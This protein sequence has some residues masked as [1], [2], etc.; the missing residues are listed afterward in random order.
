MVAASPGADGSWLTAARNFTKTKSESLAAR[1]EIYHYWG[2]AWATLGLL[3]TIGIVPDQ[4]PVGAGLTHADYQEV[5]R[6]YAISHR[7]DGKPYLAEALHPDTGSFEGHDGYNHSEHYFHSG[8]CDLIITGLVGVVPSVD[9]EL[10]I[11]PLAPADWDYFALDQLQYQGHTLTVFW[12]RTGQR[13]GHGAGLQVW[14]NGK[15]VARSQKLEALEV[16]LPDPPETAEPSSTVRTNFAVNNDGWYFPRFTSSFANPQTP[17]NKLHDG[18]S[19]YH[20][21]PPN[22]W[23]CQGSPNPVDWVVVDFGTARTFDEIQLY[24]LD[25]DG[26]TPI[27][28]PRSATLESWQEGNWQPIAA[29]PAL[30]APTGHRANR[31]R[32]EPISTERVRCLLSTRVR[33]ERV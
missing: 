32:L 33:P 18:N 28:A 27:A 29:M 13:Y 9:Q 3:E 6:T 12:D 2:T 16:E 8:F 20:E 19:W 5:L 25:D 7:K 15:L 24:F 11:K 4:E 21:H 30:S 1:D 23:T 10:T 22:R 26:K 17:I 14:A 31:Y